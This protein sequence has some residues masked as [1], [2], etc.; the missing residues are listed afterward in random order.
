M[1]SFLSTCQRVYRKCS[2]QQL[3]LKGGKMVWT[4]VVDSILAFAESPLF[5]G[6]V[7]TAIGAGI[8]LSFRGFWARRNARHQIATRLLEVQQN[9][10]ELVYSNLPLGHGQPESFKRRLFG[11]FFGRIDDAKALAD[12]V[13]LNPAVVVM[14][15]TYRKEVDSFAQKWSDTRRRVES[16]ESD[17]GYWNHYFKTFDALHELLKQIGKFKNLEALIGDMP[18]RNELGKPIP[19]SMG[20]QGGSK[21][22]QK[23]H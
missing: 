2:S 6:P 5:A 21:G 17:D 20:Y 10:G 18:K 16:T 7:G 4:E 15:S 22:A 8:S 12:Q 11:Q 13:K 9:L 3:G 14:I 19:N 23:A 1:L